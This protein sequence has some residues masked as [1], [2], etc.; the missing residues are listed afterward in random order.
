[1]TRFRDPAPSTRC[2]ALVFGDTRTARLAS[3]S[4]AHLYHLPAA[5]GGQPW[6]KTRPTGIAIGERPA[7]RSRTAALHRR[8]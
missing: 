8:K 2:S 6:A 5:A 3:I 1:M 4:V 7:P